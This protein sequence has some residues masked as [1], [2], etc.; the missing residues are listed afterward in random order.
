MPTYPFPITQS[1]ADDLL[2]RGLDAVHSYLE[3]QG[4]LVQGVS[5][6]LDPPTV[7]VTADTDPQPFLAGI[8]WPT[9][10]NY[11]QAR[12]AMKAFMAEP[13]PTQAQVIAALRGVIVELAR[14]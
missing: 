3:A 14:D 5:L 10:R 12:A 4:L 13:S 11:T 9:K 6:R 2:D 1:R 7:T 8:P